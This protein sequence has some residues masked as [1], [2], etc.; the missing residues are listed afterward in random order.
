MKMMLIDNQ[1]CNNGSMVANIEKHSVRLTSG[2]RRV[3]AAQSWFRQS[4]VS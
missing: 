4:D 1:Q 3:F 2:I